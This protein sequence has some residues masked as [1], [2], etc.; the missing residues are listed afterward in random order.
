MPKYTITL[1]ERVR[2]EVEVEADDEDA[3]V[4]AAIEQWNQS[5]DPTHDFY[6]FGL[7]VEVYS[8]GT[9]EEGANN[10]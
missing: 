8:V 9:V 1:E 6:G 10:V 3:A 5:P 7:G 2:Y 4:E